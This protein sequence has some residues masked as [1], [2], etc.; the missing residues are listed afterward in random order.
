MWVGM[1]KGNDVEAEPE[2]PGFSELQARLAVGKNGLLAKYSDRIS[3]VENMRLW[4]GIMAITGTVAAGAGRLFADPLGKWM[5]GLGVA[6]GA[7]CGI[8]V[9][10]LDRRKLDIGQEAKEAQ[11]VAEEALALG[12]TSRQGYM[13]LRQEA[14]VFDEKRSYRLKAIEE[15]IG[16]VEAALQSGATDVKCIEEMLNQAIGSI[17]QAIDYSG[18][19]F[20]TLTIYRCQGT[21]IT[22]QAYRIAR[23]WTHPGMSDSG[24]NFWVKSDGYTGAAWAL[25]ISNP[26]AEV[27][28]ADTGLLSVQKQYPV[29][30]VTD[31][32]REKLYRSV[33]AIPVLIKTTNQPWGIVTATSDRPGIF[34]PD[35]D[36]NKAQ[37]VEMIRDVAR[38]AALASV[39]ARAPDIS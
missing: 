17:R 13:A 18:S 1:D 31:P 16:T 25:G 23:Q 7:L 26:A 22:E 20:F 38:I 37:N 28:L 30:N 5:T 32:E 8:A 2:I 27:I 6:V 29:R 19:D 39:L 12:R 14:R 3:H 9:V 11:S 4:I 34:S 10:V 21:G 24:R 33:A 36:R 35:E 15:M